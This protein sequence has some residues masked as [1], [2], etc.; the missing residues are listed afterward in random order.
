MVWADAHLVEKGIQQ[1]TELGLLWKTAVGEQKVPVP[2]TL[3]TSPLTRC[4]QTTRLVFGGVV[5]DGARSTFDDLSRPIIKENLRERMTD[6]TCDRRSLR[7]WIADSYPD[8]LIEAGFAERDELWRADRWEP[9]EEHVARK[10]AVLEDIFATDENHVV[11]LTVH[12]MA[13][14]AILD[15]VGAPHFRVREGTTVPLVVKAT[16]IDA[17]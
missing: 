5:G 12:T 1:V 6:H 10:Q 7:T 4:L 15:A 9:F 17:S 8:Y 3:Y 14:V 11:S 13:I 2:G 16:R